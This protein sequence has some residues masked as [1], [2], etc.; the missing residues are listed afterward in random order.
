MSPAGPHRP[1]GLRISDLVG[2]VAGYGL[3][4]LLGKSLW[5]RSQPL[6]GVP[7]LFF[8]LVFLW[9]GLA[10]SGPI[11][12][13]L[14]R[15]AGGRKPRD[16]RPEKPGRLISEVPPP[17]RNAAP[18]PSKPDLPRYSRPE[19]AWL[20]IGGYW[21]AL[22]VFVV[23]ARTADTPWALAGLVPPFVAAGLWLVVPRPAE[24]TGL[25]KSWTHFA[26]TSLLWTWPIAWALMILLSRSL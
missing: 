17:G 14:E 4:A 25:E 12:L 22:T 24:P 21:I 5:P 26:A 16:P 20:I 3:A 23:P 2:L 15:R 19:L 7:S 9:L 13:P 11:L 6:T 10:M 18:P 1:R 8:G